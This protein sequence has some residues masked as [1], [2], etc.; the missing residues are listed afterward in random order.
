MHARSGRARRSPAW[1]A[2]A[3]AVLGTASALAQTPRDTSRAE[4]LVGL[5]RLQ[6]ERGDAAAAILSFDEADRISPFKGSLL[7]EYF[8]A[9]A[10]AHAQTAMAVGTRVLASEPGRDDVR[11][12]LVGLAIEAHDEAAVERL[13]RPRLSTK[14]LS[15]IWPRRLGES[16]LRQRRPAEAV[17]W[18]EEAARRQGALPSDLA[19]AAAGIEAAGASAEARLAAWTR[20]PAD[21]WRGNQDWRASRLRAMVDALKPRDVVG[22]VEDYVG[23]FPADRGVRAMAVEVSVRAGRPDRALAHLAVL[24]QGDDSARWLRRDADVSILAGDPLRATAVLRKLV[25]SGDAVQ[26]DRIRLAHLLIDA[27]KRPEAAAVLATEEGRGEAC[28]LDLLDV[29]ARL[30]DPAFFSRFLEPRRAGCVARVEWRW[31]AVDQAVGAGLHR[32]ALVLIE[33]LATAPGASAAVRLRFGQLLLW[34]GLPHEAIPVLEPLAAG[35]DNAPALDALA[36]ACRGTARPADAWAA[37]ERI[38]SVGTPGA[39]RRLDLAEMAIEADAPERA[40]D[41]ADD[42][43]HTHDGEA[44]GNGELRRR[45]EIVA[46]RALLARSEPASALHRLKPVLT[47]D[48]SPAALAALLDATRAMRGPAAALALAAEWRL[49]EVE[50]A[51]LAARISLCATLTGDGATAARLAGRVASLSSA[52]ARQLAVEVALAENRTREAAAALASQLTSNPKDPWVLELSAVVAATE[53]RFADAASRVADARALLPESTRLA[54]REAEWLVRANS[55]REAFANLS[56]LQASHPERIDA[57]LALA[58]IHVDAG[59]VSDALALLGRGVPDWQALPEDGIRLAALALRQRGTFADALATLRGS[60]S[61]SL[62]LRL[63]TAQLTWAV[64]GSSA[65]SAA[66]ERLASAPDCSDMVFEA[67]ARAA[68]DPAV[69]L[70]IL[71]RGR[72]QFPDSADLNGELALAAWRMGRSDEALSAARQAIRTAPDR[73]Q[74][75]VVA[76][77]ALV[78]SG[79][80]ADLSLL[81]ERFGARFLS[82]PD[83][84]YDFVGLASA[85]VRG[86]A[87]PVAVKSLEWTADLLSAHPDDARAAVA[88]ARALSAVDRF[89]EG[90]GVLDR[91][92]AANP[93]NPAVLHLRA[94]LLSY[95]GDYARS[96]AAYDAY[97]AAAPDDI[98]ARRQQARVAGWAQNYGRALVL[99]DAARRRASGNAALSAE[100]EAKAAF[101]RWSWRQAVPAYRRWLA[102][103]PDNREARF[104][105]AQS[106]ERLGSLRE[107]DGEYAQLAETLPVHAQAVEAR[108]WMA[109][110]SAARLAPVTEVESSSGY[111]GQRL[112]DRVRSGARFERAA[113]LRSPWGYSVEAAWRRLSAPRF[114]AEGYDTAASVARRLGRS[115]M[116]DAAF[117]IESNAS[118]LPSVVVGRASAHWKAN[119]TWSFETGVSRQSF[120]ENAGTARAGLTAGGAS[121]VAAARRP[122]W[123]ASLRTTAERL[124]DGNRRGDA[125]LDLG[126]RLRS[127]RTEIRALAAGE[128]IAF[129]REDPLYFSPSSLQRYDAGVE[130]R[131]QLRRKRFD[132]DRDDTFAAAFLAGVDDRGRVYQ[133]GRTELSMELRSGTAIGARAV[134]VRSSVYRQTSVS[135]FLKVPAGKR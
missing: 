111:G 62:D 115:A 1:L 116:V 105:L 101:Y 7:V 5:A 16:L 24:E 48:A 69:R 88:R 34:A 87:D 129:R 92:L 29:V 46:G 78:R 21:A 64:D 131:R 15:A 75:W 103:E 135:V 47:R 63:M 43:I 134:V 60:S 53:G 12:R 132:T 38:L 37:A 13:V 76:V 3:L 94:D 84:V 45:A 130:M 6:R 31:R 98:D 25:A 86:A 125:R 113:S 18:F 61:T 65:G 83:V 93:A 123:N 127:G 17:T 35:G 39:S 107:A 51:E 33:P 49:E 41:L 128:V 11:D 22:D 106:L 110:R 100:R 14:P 81:L 42:V 102:I 109:T 117:G 89:S 70:D 9:S 71:R 72:T 54:V 121:L 32:Q 52:R 112:L 120:L 122:G 57:R 90:V 20:V 10:G 44:R 58:R 30:G 82:R 74:P 8:W 40:L 77:Q 119:D 59:R 133:T 95:A 80:T 91:A 68:A 50:D 114:V 67:W 56:K 126:V 108:E 99:F 66:F 79:A 118:W 96:L 73:V 97:L 28:S 23:R 4:T 85:L 26:A 124:S 36:D 104:E 55:S 19:L 2:L 27:S